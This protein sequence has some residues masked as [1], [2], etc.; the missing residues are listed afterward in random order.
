MAVSRARSHSVYAWTTAVTLFMSSSLCFA[1]TPAPRAPAPAQDE[2][3]DLL[4]RAVEAFEQNQFAR[5]Y[6]LFEEAYSLRPNARV[7]RGLGIAALRLERYTQAKRALAAAL[8]DHRQP[9]TS[10]QHEE[11]SKLLS[12]MQTNLGTLR[13]ELT[14]PVPSDY[15]LWVDRKPSAE[16]AVVVTAGGHDVTARA[17]GYE[18]QERHVE[19]EAGSTLQLELTLVPSRKALSKNALSPRNAAS[20]PAAAPTRP[21]VASLPDHPDEPQR[22]RQVDNKTVFE[23]WWFWTAIGVVA[24]GGVVTAILMTTPTST[25]PYEQGNFGKGIAL[26]LERTP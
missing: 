20:A 10:R 3:K 1:Q 17:P 19:I 12:W 5:A 9:L 15:E 2:Y 7:Q 14:S 21:V 26:A 8:E 25:K 24:A 22:D 18:Q 4:D 13:V 11:V 6:D 23:R 16:T